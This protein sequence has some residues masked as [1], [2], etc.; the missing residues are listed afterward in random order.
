MNL[1]DCVIAVILGYCL[2]RGIFRGLIK[3]LSSIIGVL[4]GLYGA[5]TYYPHLSNLL[6]RWIS[7][8]GYLNI[9]SCLLIFIV[10]YIIVSMLGVM[11]KY[12]MNVAFLGW[13]DRLGGALLGAVKGGLIVAALV[14]ILT[15]FL[16]KNSHVLRDSMGARYTIEVSATLVHLASKDVKQ[17]F[18]AKKK[19][20]NK[21]WQTKKL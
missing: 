14:L 15:T 17:L 3:E 2:I 13:T 12:F 8:S 7:D 16:P 18:S 1:L 6:A 21:A 9:L 5:Y 4:A 10:V 20:L 11:I 19:E